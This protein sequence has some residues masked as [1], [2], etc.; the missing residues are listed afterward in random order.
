M[1]CGR[2]FFLNSSSR[3]STSTSILDMAFSFI[4][5]TLFPVKKSWTKVQL[6]T[7]NTGGRYTYHEAILQVFHSVTIR[8]ILVFLLDDEGVHDGREPVDELVQVHARSTFPGRR[9]PIIFR[10]PEEVVKFG[11]DRRIHTRQCARQSGGERLGSVDTDGA[12]ALRRP[13]TS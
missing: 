1:S 5:G 13:A 10:Q 3:K 8:L 9:R 4:I 7:R 6:R 2:P 12:A 11:R